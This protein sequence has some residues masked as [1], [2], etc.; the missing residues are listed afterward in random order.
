MKLSIAVTNYSWPGGPA[1]IAPRLAELART[2]DN[3]RARH[4]VGRRSPLADG[5][6]RQHRRTDARGLH[7]P[8]LPRRR[9][10]RRPA[11]HDGH[12]GDDALTRA[13]G[14]DR[15]HPRRPLGRPGLA[16]CRRRLPVRHPRRWRHR[17]P[18]ARCPRAGLRRTPAAT[19][20]TSRSRSAAASP[21]GRRPASSPTAAAGSPRTASTTSCSSPPAPGTPAETSTPFSTPPDPSARSSGPASTDHRQEVAPCPPTSTTSSSTPPTPTGRPSSSPTLLGTGMLPDWGPFVR[22][23]TSNRVT[24]DYVRD[25]PPFAEQ[26]CAFLVDDATFD[27]AHR[28]LLD[29]GTPIY[30]DPFRAN[31]RRDQP[32]LRRAWRLLRR[33]RRPPIGAHHRSLRPNPGGLTTR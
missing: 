20:T 29:R 14:Q 33:P 10:H 22:V 15:H 27:A 12:L 24:L 11:R 9:H 3:C 7:H 21:P 31:T 2:V 13:A 25:D 17:S 5:P 30:A 23:Q 26:H 16:R 19:P 8:R 1:G 6:Q 18:Q 32:P 4:P 28:Q